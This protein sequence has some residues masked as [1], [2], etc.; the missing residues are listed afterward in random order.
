LL[1]G[2]SVVQKESPGSVPDQ[3]DEKDGFRTFLLGDI[4]ELLGWINFELPSLG[5]NRDRF[6]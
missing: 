2:Q 5:T 6:S 1:A 4:S 3:R